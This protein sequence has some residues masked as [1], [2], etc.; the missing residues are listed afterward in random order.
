M[1]LKNRI[2]FSIIYRIVTL[3]AGT[4]RYEVRN[5][6][7]YDKLISEGKRVVMA[8]WHDQLLPC[9]FFHRN[10]GMVTIASDSRDGDLITYAL[11]KWGFRAARGS[12][13]RG[14][15]KAALKAVKLSTEYNVPCAI[16]VDGPKGPRHEVKPGAAFIAK[17]L[18]KVILIGLMSARHFKR[19]NSWDKF[20][21]PL[22]FAKITVTYSEPIFISE[23]TDEKEIEN[24]TKNLQ[25]RMT[26]LT[27]EVS[28]FFV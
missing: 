22:P 27:R 7:T 8:I 13:T 10:E 9:T 19:F 5:R 23:S 6:H 21:L 2:L 24:D 20:I 3:Y 18:D 15:V 14:G 25:K 26:E 28:P 11:N 1:K 4:W 17:K 12:S 16:T